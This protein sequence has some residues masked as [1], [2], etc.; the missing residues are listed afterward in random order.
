MLVYVHIFTCAHAAQRNH[1]K[2]SC[3]QSSHY[4]EGQGSVAIS[5]EDP[6]SMAGRPLNCPA[7][8]KKKNTRGQTNQ[9]ARIEDRGLSYIP[10][11][12]HG[13]PLLA[14]IEHDSPPLIISYST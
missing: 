3:T 10:G 7:L 2:V 14:I 12:N 11:I 9:S 1:V 4:G 5:V 6:I 8:Q 13:S